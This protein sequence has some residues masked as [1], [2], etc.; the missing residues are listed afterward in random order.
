MTARTRNKRSHGQRQSGGQRFRLNLAYLALVIPLSLFAYLCWDFFFLQDDA[1]ITLRY[2]ENFLS[3]Q[4]L[5]WN[6][7]TRV[8]GYTNFLWLIFLIL[9]KQLGVD[10][11]FTL[12]FFGPLLSLV[13]LWLTFVISKKVFSW[14]LSLKRALVMALVVTLTL[15]TNISFVYWTV[16]GLETALFTLLTLLAFYFYYQRSWALAPVLTLAALTRPEGL[17][18]AFFFPLFGMIQSR[19]IPKRELYILG[20]TLI[21]LIPFLIFKFVYFGGVAP[22]PFYAKTVWDWAQLVAGVEYFGEFQFHY[23]FFG[24]L[25][26]VP[27]FFYRKSPEIV[28][29]LLLY[30]FLYMLY[31]ILVGGD[32]L[33]VGRFFLPLLAP[34]YISFVYAVTR[35]LRNHYALA[36]VFALQITLQLLVPLSAARTSLGHER[37][38][39]TQTLEVINELQRV[40]R[41]NFSLA[42][43]TI[44]LSGFLLRGHDVY[45]MVGL[46]DTTIARHP[47]EPI[48]ELK[49][50]WRERKYNAE[51][52]LSQAPDYIS[53]STGMK[54]SSPGEKA[55]FL[56][57]A[58]LNSYRSVS[59]YSPSGNRMID[60]YK[61]MKPIPATLEK[62]IDAKFVEAYTEAFNRMINEEYFVALKYLDTARKTLAPLEYAY[63][64]YIAGRCLSGMGRH[65]E[66]QAALMTALQQDP[67]LFSVYATL[68]PSLYPYPGGR[69]RALVFRDQIQRLA[70]WTLPQLD[71][72]AGYKK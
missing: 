45:D 64:Y 53:F 29:A 18:L 32:V 14:E 57:P 42:T 23:G 1:F 34:L 71:R 46:T 35:A 63:V 50:T 27:A 56:Y 60:V 37:G 22:N 6:Y 59:F 20:M 15:A 52:I 40:D 3:G 8:E 51:Y 19:R 65:D 49:T 21:P 9:F 69:E 39:Y 2:A 11:I 43:S 66:S 5:V 67:D 31:I 58:F 24:M 16:A 26:I 72:V 41:S 38:L 13:T 30:S 70:P 12:S 10:Y 17:L 36:T 33:K 25:I 61:R 4:G 54:P 47:Q 68:Y 55:L 44:G 48:E 7:G 62:R 28:K